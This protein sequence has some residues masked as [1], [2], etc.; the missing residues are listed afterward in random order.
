LVQGACGALG[1]RSPESG[2]LHQPLAEQ[3]RAAQ[4]PLGY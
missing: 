3:P 1:A 2:A 4:N